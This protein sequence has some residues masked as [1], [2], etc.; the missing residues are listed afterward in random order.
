MLVLGS[1]I[2]EEPVPEK[3]G[4]KPAPLRAHYTF[5]DHRGGYT[6]AIFPDCQA[7]PHAER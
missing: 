1:G 3:A 5:E 4:I 2:G 6:S 7:P